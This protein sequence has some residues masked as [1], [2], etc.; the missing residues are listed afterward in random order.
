M[1]SKSM[2]WFNKTSYS[3]LIMAVSFYLADKSQ[4]EPYYIAG[5]VTPS[6]TEPNTTQAR[7]V[8]IVQS[9]RQLPRQMTIIQAVDAAVNW[10]PS[11]TQSIAK[12]QQQ[13]AQVDLAESHYYPQVSAGLNNSYTNTY[14]TAGM[15]PS[16][17][18]SVSQVLYDF[19]KI[20]SAVSAAKAAVASSQASVL[21]NI[22]QIAHDTATTAVQIM[23][24]QRLVVIADEQMKSLQHIGQLIMQRNQAGASSRSDVVQTETRIEGA[25]AT[26]MQY[27]ASLQR[28]KA[29]LTTYTGLTGEPMLSE[30]LPMAL[31]QACHLSHLNYQAVP[32]VMVA[33]ADAAQARAQLSLANAQMRPTLSLQPEVTH[34][35]ND[36]YSNSEMLDKTQYSA[37]LKLQMPL[38]Q[39]G[40]LSA[41]R[42][43]AQQ[44]VASA[45]SAVNVAQLE[46]MQKLTTASAEAQSL[47]QSL[48]V[49]HRQQQ[50]AQQTRD[51]YQDQYLQLG[52][53]P[54]LDLLNSDQEIY[55]A[56]F[57][58]VQTQT[59][60]NR[61]QLDCLFSSGQLRQAFSLNNRTIQGVEIRQ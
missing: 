32:G 33:W 23:G 31:K 18:V 44:G 7:R 8:N 49:Q 4:A 57:N 27:Q 10:H 53:R 39:G 21:L 51:L 30:S 55:E 34:Y 22:D 3:L 26:L 46:A 17:V 36:R 54:L 16:M 5:Q 59:E 15:T 45:E 58:Q 47:Q 14:R 13:L 20:T 37:W 9:T 61:L 41:A 1:R 60:L 6:F 35:F 43:S 48:R 56:R 50:L 42:E 11:V 2:N 52:T 28:F 38:Y 29:L 40:G 25:Q 12:L 24:Y 19:G